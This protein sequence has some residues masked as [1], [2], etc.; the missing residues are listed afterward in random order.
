M[1]NSTIVRTHQHSAGAKKR[2]KPSYWTIR[3]GGEPEIQAI[4]DA[5]GNPTS[6][7]IAFHLTE[8]DLEVA[9]AL[10]AKANAVLAD[11]RG[12]RKHYKLTEQQHQVAPA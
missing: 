1:I 3:W 2:Q 4:C 5:Q 6:N 8:D 10:L 11:K 9:D 7:P 12:R